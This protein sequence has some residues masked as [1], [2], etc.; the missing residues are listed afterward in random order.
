MLGGSGS[1]YHFELILKNLLSENRWPYQTKIRLTKFSSDT[2]FCPTKFSSPSKN[3]V[4]F[5]RRIMFSNK[6]LSKTLVRCSI[7][8]VAVFLDTS[9]QRRKWNF[10]AGGTCWNISVIPLDKTFARISSKF[11]KF[12]KIFVKVFRGHIY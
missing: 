6:F 3:F 12:E 5:V 7:L 1:K 4:N 2:I 9:E 11:I 10:L 8:Q